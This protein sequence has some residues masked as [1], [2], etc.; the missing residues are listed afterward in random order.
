MD[1]SEE[2]YIVLVLVHVNEFFFIQFPWGTAA[3]VAVPQGL[4]PLHIFM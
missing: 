2:L 4:L 1:Q 3:N